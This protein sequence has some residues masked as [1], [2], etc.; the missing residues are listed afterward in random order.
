VAAFL[1]HSFAWRNLSALVITETEL[2]LIAAPAM[3][4]LRS[5]PKNG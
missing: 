4:G 2:K 1:V 3:M 5:K